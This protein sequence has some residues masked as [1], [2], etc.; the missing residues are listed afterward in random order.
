MTVAWSP[1]ELEQIG[2]AE[3]LHIAANRAD[4]T[5]GARPVLWLI[6]GGLY[7]PSLYLSYGVTAP[8]GRGNSE[9][10]GVIGM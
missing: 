6:A 7:A 4:G 2:S 10:S 3:E 8:C 5:L 1:D 9:A